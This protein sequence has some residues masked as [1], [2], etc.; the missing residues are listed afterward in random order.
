M[1]P[2]MNV[3]RQYE[4]LEEKLDQA[5]LRVLHSGKYIMGDDVGEWEKMFAGY[6]GVKYAVGVGNGTDALV[7]ALMAAGVGKG[8]EVITSAMS[9]FS[10]A[11]AIAMV[12]AIPVFVDCTNDTYTLDPKKIEE[13][14]TDRTK[15]IIP[16]HLYGQCADM[17]KINDIAARNNLFVLEDAAQA[18]GATYKGRK[19]GSLGDAACFSFFPTKNLG[20]AGDG[21]I[22]ATD[23]E[24]LYKKCLALRVHGSG[25]NGLYAY[26]EN[27]QI[28]FSEEIDFGGNLPK[29]YNFVIGFNSRLDTLQAALLK[30]KL[31]YLDKWNMQ[32]REIA[33]EYENGIT[34]PA[35]TKPFCDKDNIH[36]YYVYVLTVEQ[37]E[38]FR[39][40]MESKG[41][42]TGVYFPVPL[43]LQK[44]FEDLGYKEGDMPNAEFIAKHGV[45]I[46]M[47]PE[48]TR[49]ER[50]CVI[51]NVN[52]YVEGE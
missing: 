5:A 36:I 44:A 10:T 6:I 33:S 50:R 12:G 43:H 49:D 45:A 20:C 24:R 17:D 14:I 22:I 3:T 7:I 41:I 37:R 4:S 15:A 35:I 27:K 40:Y 1:I 9:F 39:Q 11:E 30:E 42:G 8:D 26:C 29:Y 31:P 23:D 34:N 47:Y 2:L 16:V 19:A 32:R 28:D 51:E 25:I 52:L 13:R 48:L 18:A 38:R 46:P 21:G